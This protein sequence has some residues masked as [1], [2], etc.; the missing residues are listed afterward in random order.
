MQILCFTL[1]YKFEL[2]S[3][4]LDES[5]SVFVSCHLFLVSCLSYSDLCMFGHLDQRLHFPLTYNSFILIPFSFY[6]W[7]SV[8]QCCSTGYKKKKPQIFFLFSIVSASPREPLHI[9]KFIYLI[10]GFMHSSTE[11]CYWILWF[12]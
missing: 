6:F 5:V 8:I 1:V 10:L 2:L 7:N 4:Y 9:F 3:C 12:L 11:N